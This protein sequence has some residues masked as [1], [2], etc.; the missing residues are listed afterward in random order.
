M[1]CQFFHFCAK[2]HFWPPLCLHHVVLRS[3]FLPVNSCTHSLFLAIFRHA[4]GKLILSHSAI[5][6]FHKC[7]YFILESLHVTLISRKA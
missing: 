7:S 1:C 6:T 3:S 2:S 4:P 5:D